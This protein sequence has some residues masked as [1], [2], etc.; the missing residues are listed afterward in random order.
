MLGMLDAALNGDSELNHQ[1]WARLLDLWKL[2]FTRGVCK[3]IAH[4]K[5]MAGI[6]ANGSEALKSYLCK[7]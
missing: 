2:V 4:S 5:E 3:A 6:Q 7:D 1:I